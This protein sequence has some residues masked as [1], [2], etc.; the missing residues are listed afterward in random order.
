MQN[1]HIPRNRTTF[2]I[3]TISATILMENKKASLRYG[4]RM[5]DDI[6]LFTDA[7]YAPVH[8]GEFDA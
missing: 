3:R 2:V 4:H 1:L 6:D 5:S 7:E 8:S